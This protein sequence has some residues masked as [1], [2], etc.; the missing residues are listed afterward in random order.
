MSDNESISDATAELKAYE[1]AL[2]DAVRAHDQQIHSL[3]VQH[4]RDLHKREAVGAKRN[5]PALS[6]HMN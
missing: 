6:W 5:Y 2:R 4:K 3:R 1:F